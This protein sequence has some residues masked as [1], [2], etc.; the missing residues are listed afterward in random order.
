MTR[1][2]KKRKPYSGRGGYPKRVREG[3]KHKTKKRPLRCRHC[4]RHFATLGEINA[5]YSAAGHVKAPSKPK[6]FKIDTSKYSQ[7]DIDMAFGLLEL[8]KNPQKL[9]AEMRARIRERARRRTDVYG[10]RYT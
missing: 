8:L 1:P 7:E 2:P 10:R 9:K 4:G 6:R 5:H 3:T